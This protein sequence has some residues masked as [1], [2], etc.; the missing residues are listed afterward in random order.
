[1]WKLQNRRIKKY[2]VKIVSKDEKRGIQVKIV[3][4]K[5]IHTKKETE[6]EK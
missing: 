4:N 3:S 1:M 5:F 2:I 6:I